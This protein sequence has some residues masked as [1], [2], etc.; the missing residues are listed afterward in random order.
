[1]AIN[2]PGPYG[3]EISYTV[4]GFTHSQELNVD[5]QGTPSPGDTPAS[6]T[7]ETI[8]LVGL[9]LDTAVNEWVDLIKA[10]LN[11]STSYSDYTLWKYTP[12]T[13][14]RI[15]ITSASLS[16][17]GTDATAYRPAGQLTF[18]FR[19]QEG[20]TMRVV[21]LESTNNT[22]A[23]LPI[24]SLAP[25][26]SKDIADYV[27]SSDRWILARDTSYPIAGINWSPTENERIYKRRFR[28]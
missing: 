3:I 16:Q 10:H 19:T 8:D 6:I 26:K 9:N 18:S 2:F 13:T 17:I 12:L 14:E 7:L 1:M 28:S 20:N 15:F 21:I 22:D 24:G 4:D 27:L 23:Q 11:T 5:C 25:G